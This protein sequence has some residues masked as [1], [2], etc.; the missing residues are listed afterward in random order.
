MKKILLGICLLITTNLVFSQL[1]PEQEKLYKDVLAIRAK[2]LHAISQEKH[3][4]LE[5]VFDSNVVIIRAHLNQK[6]NK[7]Q[8]KNAFA[9]KQIVYDTLYDLEVIP[10]FY[11]DNKICILIGS[12]KYHYQ[13]PKKQ[14]FTTDFTDIYFLNKDNHWKNIYFHSQKPK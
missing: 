1:T 2:K 14:V 3:E 8:L 5:E 7:N 11:N 6:F 4:T 12:I 13:K 9:Q 10:Q